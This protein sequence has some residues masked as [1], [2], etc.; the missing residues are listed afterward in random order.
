MWEANA[1]NVDGC[2]VAGAVTGWHATTAGSP[3]AGGDAGDAGGGGAATPAVVAVAVATP[4]ADDDPVPW[5]EF[6]AA[7]NATKGLS[8]HVAGG[9]FPSPPDHGAGATVHCASDDDGRAEAGGAPLSTAPWLNLLIPPRTGGVPAATAPAR[10]ADVAYRSEAPSLPLSPSLSPLPPSLSHG[11]PMPA[12]RGRPV[13]AWPTRPSLLPSAAAGP[14][15]PRQPPR[16]PLLRER[17]TATQP[18]PPS[19]PQ[20]FL[21][22]FSPLLPQARHGALSSQGE[23]RLDSLAPPS[24]YCPSRLPRRGVPPPPM[25]PV[26]PRLG[27]GEFGLDPRPPGHCRD[28]AA[29]SAVD[30]PLQ[31]AQGL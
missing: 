22:D 3:V 6:Y 11:L 19:E 7:T 25:T 17:S 24:I 31:E 27:G 8:V 26:S 21:Q 1:L 29:G 15:Q 20:T 12:G 13:D 2:V 9:P 10:T 14:S 4:A 23:E 18:R 30:R 16:V 5:L 28:G